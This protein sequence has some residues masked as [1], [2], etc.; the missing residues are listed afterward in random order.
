MQA[1]LLAHR[2]VFTTDLRT[3]DRVWKIMASHD[4]GA[5][6]IE[7]FQRRK[8]YKDTEERS[9]MVAKYGDQ[10][11]EFGIAYEAI[12][13][14]PLNIPSYG[15][16]RKLVKLAKSPA[17]T[18]PKNWPLLPDSFGALYQLSFCGVLVQAGIDEGKITKAMTPRQ[19]AIFRR[20]ANL[21]MRS[22][23]GNHLPKVRHA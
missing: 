16:F 11:P 4:P 8:V 14:D 1:A 20:E 13:E 6:R 18:D 2:L 12:F 15:H 9:N 23:Q 17:L 21:K 5:F 7:H 22:K 10:Y 3:G 19:A